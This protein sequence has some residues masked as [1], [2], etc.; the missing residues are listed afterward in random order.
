MALAAVLLLLF[1]LSTATRALPLIGPAPPMRVLTP[2]GR[3]QRVL[4]IG[5]QSS[6]APALR[7]LLLSS[8]PA[9]LSGLGR[10][11]APAM[12]ANLSDIGE[13]STLVRVADA[14]FVVGYNSYTSS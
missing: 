14:A 9:Q 13:P 12:L 4:A 8:Q 7:A 6:L 3:V 10:S 1:L 5:A 11:S 2:P